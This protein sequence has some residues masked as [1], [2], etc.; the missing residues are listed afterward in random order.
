MTNAHQK[1]PRKNFVPRLLP[2][3]L[4]ILMLGV[5]WSS[6][7]RWA[8]LFNLDSVARVSG[9]IWEPDVV[10]PVTFL[11]TWPLRWLPAAQVPLA[12]NAFPPCLR[13]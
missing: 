6:L 3:L 7:N 10:N 13:P 4:A 1:D 12:L 9:W 5:Y 2:W 11:L 8:S